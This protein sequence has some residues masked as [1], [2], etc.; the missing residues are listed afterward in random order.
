[1]FG[2]KVAKHGRR[3]SRPANVPQHLITDRRYIQ[4]EN[5]LEHKELYQQA[6]DVRYQMFH[7]SIDSIRIDIPTAHIYGRDDIWRLHSLD[8]A[9]LCRQD[10]SIMYEHEG[11][12]EIPKWAS[13][14]ICDTI[15]TLMAQLPC[16]S[17]GEDDSDGF[18]S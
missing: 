7:P 3:A 16:M 9:Q 1:M 4:G 17:Q 12:H 10:R 15:E 14:E 18:S 8:L 6:E 2:V 11:G 5:V 13:D